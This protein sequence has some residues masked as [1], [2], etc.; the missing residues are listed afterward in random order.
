VTIIIFLQKGFLSGNFFNYE[1]AEGGETINQVYP[2]SYPT[3]EGLVEEGIGSSVK[4]AFILL[5][6]SN[7]LNSLSLKLKKMSMR[8]LIKFIF[9]AL[10]SLLLFL[11]F[12]YYNVNPSVILSY[13]ITI[14]LY[15]LAK[16]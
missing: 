4:N 2:L 11:L 5:F 10:S 13:L 14:T 16:I 7:K 9:K 6:L 12:I 8:Q 15:D 3:F 1:P